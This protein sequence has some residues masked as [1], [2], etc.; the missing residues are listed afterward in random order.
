MIRTTFGDS[1]QGMAMLHGRGAPSS[2]EELVTGSHPCTHRACSIGHF[3]SPDTAATN[4]KYAHQ[5]RPRASLHLRR[6][7]IVR[8]SKEKDSLL[9]TRE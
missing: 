9:D 2:A 8:P 6:L 5:V 7:A 3:S 4:L 1:R